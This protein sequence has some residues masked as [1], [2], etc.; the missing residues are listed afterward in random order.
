MTPCSLSGGSSLTCCSSTSGGSAMLAAALRRRAHEF[1]FFCPTAGRR[2]ASA[3][4]EHSCSTAGR[5]RLFILCSEA[6]GRQNT[7]T[8]EKTRLHLS[9]WPRNLWA[10]HAT[11][12]PWASQSY[13]SDVIMCNASLSLWQ[14]CWS[15][16]KIRHLPTLLNHFPYCCTTFG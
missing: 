5:S 13:W 9:N 11:T 16:L 1:L 6:G 2:E 8:K 14:E 7:K 4:W 10:S 3:G 15:K 12:G